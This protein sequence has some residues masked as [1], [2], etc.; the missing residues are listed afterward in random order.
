[1]NRREERDEIDAR[2]ATLPRP[3]MDEGARARIHRRARE[4]FVASAGDATP[5]AAGRWARFWNRA[6]EP[7]GVA[8]ATV[9]YL[10]WTTQALAAIDWG[11]IALR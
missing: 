6:L 3:T 5:A 11:R 7:A 9:V 1:M 10:L 4:V 2:L 8:I